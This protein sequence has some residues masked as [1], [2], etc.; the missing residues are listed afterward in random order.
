MCCFTKRKGPVQGFDK[1]RK[2]LPLAKPQ[3]NCTDPR[4]ALHTYSEGQIH[5]HQ[6]KHIEARNSARFSASD[7]C[8]KTRAHNHFWCHFYLLWLKTRDREHVV[9]LLYYKKKSLSFTDVISSMWVA[10]NMGHK[11]HMPT[12]SRLKTEWTWH[13]THM[14]LHRWLPYPGG[15]RLPHISAA[16]QWLTVIPRCK[17]RHSACSQL[18]RVKRVRCILRLYIAGFQNSFVA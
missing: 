13:T 11:P 12:N 5:K 6:M 4:K 10:T 15:T 18:F 14:L 16:V 1:R 2:L 8:T 3:C 17:F 9:V 7:A